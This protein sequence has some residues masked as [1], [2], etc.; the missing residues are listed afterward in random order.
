MLAPSSN[1]Q[2]GRRDCF[3]LIGRATLAAGFGIMLDCGGGSS[4]GGGT[5]AGGGNNTGTSCLPSGS[6]PRC[7]LGCRDWVAFSP[8]SPFNPDQNIFPD[9]SQLT[10]V[11]QQL[12]QEGWRGL[13]T[14]S[15]DGILGDVPR[16]AKQAGF[17][18]LI[19][20]LFWFD[21]VQLERELA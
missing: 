19:A 10:G 15:L 8:P 5:K 14:F 3:A 11:L 18:K 6:V 1:R 21:N 9:E 20:G 13:V 2:I 17:A 7:L 4:E 12:F 16:I